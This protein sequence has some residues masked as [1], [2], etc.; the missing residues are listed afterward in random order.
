MTSE[1]NYR[2]IVRY[3]T[4]RRRPYAGGT[5]EHTKRAIR[6]AAAC[7]VYRDGLLLYQRRRRDSGC[8][9]ELEV[10]V[11]ERRR[12]HI[13]SRCHVSPSG[14]HLSRDVTCRAVSNAYWWRGILTQISEF[15]KRCEVC[16]S[17]ADRIRY[18]PEILSGELGTEQR[19]VELDAPSG[20]TLSRGQLGGQRSQ[21]P[22]A[23]Q[24]CNQ[25][26]FHTIVKQTS[27][28]HG[29]TVLK[30]LNEQRKAN[31][32]CDIALLIEGEEHRAHKSVL[33]AN[34]KYFQD[35]FTEKGATSN[36]EAVV[37]LAGF[38]KSSFLPVLDFCYTSCLTFEALQLDDVVGVAEHLQMEEVLK[39]CRQIGAEMEPRRAKGDKRSR[40]PFA[41]ERTCFSKP[42]S[43]LP[44]AYSESKASRKDAQLFEGPL[45]KE[46]PCG[47]L[48][49]GRRGQPGVIWRGS[50][51]V[52]YGE[53]RVSRESDEAQEEDEEE[54]EVYCVETSEDE[55]VASTQSQ[56]QSV[57]SNPEVEVTLEMDCI[58]ATNYSYLGESG[59]EYRASPKRLE[60]WRPGA[61]ASAGRVK[62]E[63]ATSFACG[64]CGETFQAA[65]S[66]QRHAEMHGRTKGFKCAIC[67]KEFSYKSSLKTH[68]KRHVP[69]R[70]RSRS[71]PD[72]H[73][74][75]K[76]ICSACGKLHQSL[77]ELEAHQLSHA[78][79]RTHS[80]MLQFRLSPDA[81][82][83]G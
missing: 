81:G 61:A 67:S 12:L 2:A 7:Y 68:L 42:L 15:V 58:S 65:C 66:L 75:H 37:E 45:K 50:A 22:F 17:G 64:E 25:A 3:L 14:R 36:Q 32:F 38:T 9:D 80:C 78:T 5:A 59:G 30:Q 48:S 52:L 20:T 77:Y 33:A 26:A 11:D 28:G 13:F 21:K 54:E 16:R 72:R 73:H 82:G 51:A 49:G 62:V 18:L 34:S 35:L 27:P 63:N 41:R 71:D 6:K 4:Q 40:N 55:G 8:L 10:V 76:L 29:L 44:V 24:R 46:A 43:P 57:G 39:L 70:R 60:R 83:V 31:R 74:R 1:E 56:C 23:D 19:I 69:D 47:P 79:D 53:D